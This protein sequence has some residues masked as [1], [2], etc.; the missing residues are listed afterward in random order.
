MKYVERQ[1]E[2]L[3]LLGEFVSGSVVRF[4]LQIFPKVLFV[5]LFFFNL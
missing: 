3:E 4:P 2:I 1:D 5:I